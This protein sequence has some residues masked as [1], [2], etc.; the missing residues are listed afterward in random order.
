MRVALDRLY[1]WSGYAAGAC[2]M[3]IFALMLFMSV[4]RQV[5]L[6]IPSGDDFAAWAMAATAFLGLAHTF[7]R[8]EMIRVGLLL[9]KLPRRGQWVLQVFS[10]IVALTY[11]LYFTWHAGRFVHFSWTSH[12]MSNGVV[13]VPMW[14]PQIAFFAGIAI[15][16]IAI[17]DELV[18]VLRGNNPTFEK[19]P[20]ATTEELI[21]RVAEGGGV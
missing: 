13:A 7:K 21:A 17:A 15:L 9:E 14:I 19:P 12:E 20:P 1:L 16:L 18:H 3:V 8:G 6:N 11:I 4:G 2:L 10:L 5:G